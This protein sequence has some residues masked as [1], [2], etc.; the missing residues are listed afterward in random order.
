MCFEH[1]LRN[2]ERLKS[3]VI[4]QPSLAQVPSSLQNIYKELNSDVGFEVPKHGNLAEWVDQGV[5]LLNSSL[6]VEV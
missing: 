5:L 4:I 3:V 6:T 2:E 1:S